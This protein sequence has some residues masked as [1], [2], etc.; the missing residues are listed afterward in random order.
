M[1]TPR[2]MVGA[3]FVV[4]ALGGCTVLAGAPALAV[5]VRL[6]LAF[7]PFG[8]GGEPTGV[9]VDESSGNVFVADSGLRRV[10]VFGFEGGSP[11]GGLPGELTGEQTPAGKFKFG[12]EP[13]GVAVDNACFQ[14]KLSGAACTAF[15]PSNGDIYVTDVKNNVVD[16]FRING[17]GYEYVCQF[18]GYGFVGSACLKNEPSVDGASS[19]VTFGEPIGVA[20]DR[21]GNVYIADFAHND[22]DEFNSG[23]EEVRR[24]PGP[25]EPQDITVDS[26]GDIYVRKY[27]GGV[28]VKL[29][30]SSF[31]G[32][33]ESEEAIGSSTGVA[34]SLAAGRLFV[35][36]GSHLTEYNETGEAQG[37]FGAEVLSDAKGIA[38]NE[39]ND[40]V[41]VVN[42][43]THQVDAFGPV[44]ALAS[45]TTGVASSVTPTSATVEGTI[46]PESETLEA[47]CEVRYGTSPA[48]GLSTPCSPAKVGVG[49]DPVPVT[50]NLQGLQAGTLYY[51]RVVAL[52]NNGADPAPHEGTFTTLPAVEGVDTGEAGDIGKTSATLNGILKPNGLDAHYYFEYGESEAYGSVIPLSPADAGTGNAQAEEVVAA[53]VILT[54]LK[55]NTVYYYRLVASNELGVTPAG[56]GKSFKT[57][58]IDPVV[59]SESATRIFPREALLSAVVVPEEAD[60]T[61][62]FAYGPTAA[63]GSVAPLGDIAL[64]TGSEGLHALWTV[65]GLEPG[66]TYHYAVVATNAGGSTYG[67]DETFTTPAATPPVVSTGSASGVS[68]N[69]ASISGTVDPQGVPTSYEWDIGTDTTYGTRISG[70]VGSS[71]EPQALSLGLLGLAAGRIYHYR[72]V[73]TNTYGTVYGADET[74]ATPGVPTALLAS[75]VG[76]PLVP[77]PV[78]TA[79]SLSGIVT[80]TSTAGKKA[81]H[82]AR[83]KPKTRKKAGKGKQAGRTSAR[84]E[85]ASARGEWGRG[86]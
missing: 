61:Y 73:A 15:D 64:G 13:T 47:G 65:S 51:Y 82:K 77:A 71:S 45:A 70:E 33:V 18:T 49:E 32:E 54:G 86:R 66:T 75:P 56:E 22:I 16:K 11:A 36:F 63:Y 2:V 84:A 34:F 35:G 72:L 23:G 42:G 50:A 68:Q 30:R 52:N 41:Y 31:V 21:E 43:E 79:P 48:Y 3:L 67:P 57:L 62:H 38:I 44:L 27:E 4:V 25:S 5:T 29:K 81:K 8:A 28:L 58:P 17:G 55:A 69:G 80:S 46:N 20:V 26:T 6:P 60:T 74:F 9:A 1:R 10:L 39:G 59:V 7:S 78:F 24:M 76:A 19:E 40:D 14:H 37:S 83:K 12:G 53:G 85:K